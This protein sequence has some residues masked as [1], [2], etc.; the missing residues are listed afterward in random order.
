MLLVVV[1]MR[2]VAGSV[3]QEDE[4]RRTRT[5]LERTEVVLARP[6]W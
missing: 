4:V 5:R 1:R 3:T 6:P 2:S